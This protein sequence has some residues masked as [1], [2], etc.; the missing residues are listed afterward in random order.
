MLEQ[1][2]DEGLVVIIIAGASIKQ[3]LICTQS[4]ELETIINIPIL[5]AFKTEVT[6][7]GLMSPIAALGE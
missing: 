2:S 6:D 1:I 7:K 3:F 5:P 4:C